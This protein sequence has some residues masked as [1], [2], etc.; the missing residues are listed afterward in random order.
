SQGN[1]TSFAEAKPIERRAIFEEA[2]GVSK[3]KKRKIESL[4]KLERTKDNIDRCQDILNELEKQ[5]SPLKRQAKKAKIFKEKKQRLQEIEIAV[6]VE[7]IQTITNDIEEAKRSLFDLETQSAMYEASIQIQENELN[8]QRS[9]VNALEKEVN[10]LQE[11]LM[12]NMHEIQILETRKIE[13]DEKRKYTIEVGDRQAKISQLKQLLNE[14]K[15]EYD[16]RNARLTI[17]E[18]D[19]QLKTQRLGNIA[20]TISD[21]RQ[22]YE[23]ANAHYRRLENRKEVLENM[24]KQPFNNQAGVRSIMDNKN[25]L[26]GVLG[27]IAQVFKAHDGY[28]EAISTA[29]GAA[30]YNIVVKDEKSARDAIS[31][32]KRNQSG[33]ATFLPLNVCQKRYINKDHLIICQNHQGFLGVASDFVDNEQVFDV[34]KALL[35]NNVLVVDKLENGNELNR[36][37]KYQYKIVTLDGDVIFKGGSMSGGKVKNA[38]SLITL[39]K[40]LEQI[41]HLL[42][43]ALANSQLALKQLQEAQNE[44]SKLEQE[45]ME[46][47]ISIAKLEPIVDAKRAKYEKLQN[48]MQTLA[49]DADIQEDSVDDKIITSLNKAYSLRDELTTSIKLKRD[50]RMSLFQDNERKEQQLRQIRKDLNDA[51]NKIN[52]IKISQAKSETK[53]EANLNRLASEYQMTFEFAKTKVDGHIEN[54][55]E[56]VLQLRR[57]IEALGNVNMNAPEEYEEVNNRYEFLNKQI[58]ELVDSKNKIL[59]AIDEMDV[60]MTKQFKTMFN[61]I[62]NELNETFRSLFGG[63]KAKLVLEDASDILNTGIDIDVQPPGKAVQNIRLFSGGEKALIAICVIFSILKVKTVPL[64]IFDEVEAALDQSNVERFAKYL[65]TFVDQTQFI[66][67]THR[68]GTMQECEVL[69]GVTMQKQGVSQM[70]K[71]ELYDAIEMAQPDKEDK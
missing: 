9:T 17:L 45:L 57:E 35:L 23:Q 36:L 38:T 48:D 30:M 54:A 37:L 31:F 53:L 4:A 58:D 10:L 50:N 6:L 51:N 28:E 71:V 5:V 47:R 2:A 7:E 59:K 39:S 46:S 8:D 65:K 70:L 60:V 68:P 3:Y 67:V 19:I 49:P 12:R 63:G 14:A 62:N 13:I 32:L 18:K 33:R 24:S 22:Q 52:T 41:K 42:S 21:Q 43:S 64:I 44:K 25:S 16:D 66:V 27:V 15:L 34:V 55:K 29:L 61:A 11:Q 26:P 40:E 56:E 69:Y 20:L 1:V